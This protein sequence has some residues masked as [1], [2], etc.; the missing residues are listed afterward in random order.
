[1]PYGPGEPGTE[2]EQNAAWEEYVKAQ[3]QKKQGGK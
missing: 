2:D 1:M 3:N